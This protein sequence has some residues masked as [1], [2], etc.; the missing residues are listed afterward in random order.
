MS[1]SVKNSPR[2]RRSS[3]L[4]GPFI[5]IAIGVYFLLRNIG[6]VPDVLN[7]G[8]VFQL[9]PLILVFLGVNILVQQLPR[10]VGSTLSGLLGV[11]AVLFFGY[12]L[13]FGGMDG[14]MGQFGVSNEGAGWQQ[15]QVV[16]SR[17][18]VETAIVR[19]DFENPSAK[20]FALSNSNALIDGEVSFIGE[21]DFQSERNGSEAD[22]SL[23][24]RSG[25][26]DWVNPGNWGGGEENTWRIGL[27]PTVPTD[28][29]LDVG[30]G[31]TDLDLDELQLTALELD[32]GN[33]ST[34]MTL[35]AGDYEVTLDA[36][37]GSSK[38]YLP[39]NGRQTLDVDG[40]NGSTTFYLPANVEARIEFEK[41]NGGVSVDDRFELV[42]GDR[43]DG[44][45][46]T[47]GYEDAADRVELIID[48]GNGGIRVRE[49]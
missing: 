36:G 25:P 37:N 16:F 3:S 32:G 7:W 40:D 29:R 14:W 43:D 21:L 2:R 31:S 33:G 49:P 19:I 18:D 30:N 38:I 46:E 6:I 39:E 8:A 10:P 1:D 5:L 17:D 26:L 28:L 20:L 42:S 44:V 13:L 4:F 11:V 12:V 45:W 41:G 47:A 35:P 9:W 15:E 23:R 27:S 22:I 34:T 24:T 48:G